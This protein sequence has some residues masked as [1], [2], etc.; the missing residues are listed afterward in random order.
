MSTDLTFSPSDTLKALAD[1]TPPQHIQPN[2]THPGPNST[3]FAAYAIPHPP[4]ALGPRLTLTLHKEIS[5]GVA[6]FER[7]IE[8]EQEVPYF[9]SWVLQGLYI[10]PEHQRQRYATYLLLTARTLTGD[11]LCPDT[12]F[13]QPG[14][15]LW[16]HLI[17]ILERPTQPDDYHQPDNVLIFRTLLT[18]LVKTCQT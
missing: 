12:Q 18:H 16:Q 11:A 1:L 5:L 13:T 14:A 10:H 6:I 17:P 9:H 8:Y 4:H 7:D 15:N 2:Y 3:S